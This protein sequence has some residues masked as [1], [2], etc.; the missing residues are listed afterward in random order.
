V[1]FTERSAPVFNGH[2]FDN[3]CRHWQ[4]IVSH[5]VLREIH[6]FSE[7]LHAGQTRPSQESP[8]KPAH[9]RLFMIRV[10]CVPWIGI[11]YATST[12][13][14]PDHATGYKETSI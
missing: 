4:G 5:K 6:A 1:I 7:Q 2:L 10:K 13:G 12:P 11:A 8:P 3:P 9:K 14:F